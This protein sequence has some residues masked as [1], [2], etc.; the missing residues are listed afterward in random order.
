MPQDREVDVPRLVSHFRLEP[1]SSSIP[2]AILSAARCVT[3][4]IVAPFNSVGLNLYRDGRDSVAPHNEP[5][6]EIRPGFPIR[7]RLAERGG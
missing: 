7:Y 3:G 1:P 6:S 2:P 5:L 4:R